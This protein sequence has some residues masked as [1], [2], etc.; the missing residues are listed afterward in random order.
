MHTGFA[1]A[2]CHKPNQLDPVNQPDPNQP[3]IS[4]LIVWKVHGAHDHEYNYH[5][6]LH[7]VEVAQLYPQVGDSITHQWL[8]VSILP[9]VH[10]LRCTVRT[11]RSPQS[12]SQRFLA[13]K[14]FT[15]RFHRCGS[16]ILQR[17]PLV[18]RLGDKHTPSP[19]SRK[20]HHVLL[21][22]ISAKLGKQHATQLSLPISA[23]CVVPFTWLHVPRTGP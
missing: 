20:S 19:K 22:R 10:F 16:H 15:L 2:A 21:P 11:R 6:S 3:T 17:P 23:M 4:Q 12:L 5:D 14:T 9:N 18:P 7:S 13:H 1:T 8:R